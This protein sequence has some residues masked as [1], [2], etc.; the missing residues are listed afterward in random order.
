MKRI[1]PPLLALA[2]LALPAATRA[3]PRESCGEQ[4]CADCHLMSRED[5]KALLGPLVEEVTQIGYSEV[6]G[7][8]EVVGTKGGKKYPLYIDFSRQ[9]VVSGDVIRV[10]TRESITRD[11][12]YALNKVDL[13]QIPVADALVMGKPDAPHKIVVLDDPECPFCQKLFGEM[14]TVVEQRPEVAFLIKMF[15][16]PI[17][18]KAKEKAKAIICAKSLQMLEDSLAG[19]PVPAPSCTTDQVE[20]NLALGRTLGINSVPALIFPDGMLVPGYATAQ[21][22]LSLLDQALAGIPPA[23]GETKP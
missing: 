10:A 16:L 17:H 1:V 23:P 4:T 3:F 20:K 2:L 15:P 21:R 19:R 9:F 14:K 13:S 7:L 12:Y 11:R 8:F 6:P 5:A 22:I 18:P